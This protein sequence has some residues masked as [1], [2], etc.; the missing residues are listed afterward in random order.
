MTTAAVSA[1]N[2]DTQAALAAAFSGALGQAWSLYDPQRS[3]VTTQHVIMAAQAIVR[4][5][6][7][8][9][10]AFAN[11][12]Y[13]SRRSAAGIS[14]LDRF[15]PTPTPL[16]SSERVAQYVQ[17]ALAPVPDTEPE[18][19]PA[20]LDGARR[21][22]TGMLEKLVADTG[23]QQLVDNALGDRQ[24]TGWAREA[25]PNACW[26]CA[27]LA[28]RGAVY[29]SAE[30]AGLTFEHGMPANSY[31]SHCHC[32]VVPLFGRYE[33]PAHIRQWQNLWQKSTKGVTGA[34]KAWA[35]QEA[36]E[37]RSIKR[38]SKKWS[39]YG[40]KAKSRDARPREPRPLQDQQT[41]AQSMSLG[42]AQNALAVAKRLYLRE[43]DPVGDRVTW[44]RVL[45]TRL[46]LPPERLW[47]IPAPD[48]V[49][50]GLSP[51]EL[52]DALSTAEHLLGNSEDPSRIAWIMTLQRAVARRAVYAK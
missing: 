35:F 46:D 45:E 40:A 50:A 6:A 17:A 44:I 33:P 4:Q 25:R 43:G 36:Y 19:L 52:Q 27:M 9:A 37:G 23:R 39:G 7:M 29:H 3:D 18:D 31:H 2:T 38:R 8:A 26:F 21:N 15:T 12:H 47:R 14:T 10:R 51:R 1:D 32:Q 48:D 24:A 49:L 34:D 42:R 20:T 22:A 30:S 28:S 5:H 13:Q 11:E 16:P 41:I